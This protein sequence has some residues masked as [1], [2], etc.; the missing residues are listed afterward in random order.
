M[1]IQTHTGISILYGSFLIFRS[2]ESS[3]CGRCLDTELNG[4]HS[5]MQN[6]IPAG[7]IQGQAKGQLNAYGLSMSVS[8]KSLWDLLFHVRSLK[9]VSV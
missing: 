4:W 7:S 6:P 2:F 8:V 5:E 3:G 9:A 1:Y